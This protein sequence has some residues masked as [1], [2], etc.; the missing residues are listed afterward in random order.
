ML[1]ITTRNSE[2]FHT[3]HHALNYD[4]DEHGGLYLPYQLVRFTQS[5][6][7][8]FK[9]KSFNQCVAEILNIFFSARLDAWDIACC[10][11]AHALKLIPMSHKITVA[12]IWNNPEWSL[13]RFVRNL[14]CRILGNNDS[15]CPS[16]WTQIAVRIAILFGI[17][18]KLARIG[19][20]GEKKTIDIS[21]VSGD[22]VSPMA[23][24]Y[25]RAM[26]LPIGTIIFSCNENCCAWDLL[27]HGSAQI[28]PAIVST[29]TSTCDVGIP[30]NMECLIHATLG[31]DEV[32][33]FARINA[34]GNLYSLS[35]EDR[36]TLSGGMFG[37]V[38]GNNRVKSI[39]KN[40]YATSAY[41]L[42]PYSAL[43][44]GG[45]QDYRAIRAESGQTLIFTENGPLSSPG[46]VSDAI[47]ITQEELKNRIILI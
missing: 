13:S 46:F 34:S 31:K 30:A 26:G 22:F 45:L 35:D 43:A 37:A 47:G 41:I 6:L 18:A 3:S 36:N 17:F 33:R 28:N 1:Y 10:I 15:G 27:H 4:R 7:D 5:E 32:A 25:A 42:N 8:A 12:E 23:A 16:N 2:Q 29:V 40:F 24:W 11:G 39:I 20:V 14:N 44:Y 38:V 19:V 21:V 9:D